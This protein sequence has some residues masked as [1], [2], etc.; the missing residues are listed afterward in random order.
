VVDPENSDSDR[1][2]GEAGE[3]LIRGPQVFKGYWRNDE[4]TR[5]V[6]TAD[7]WFKTGDI[8]R[9][10]EDFYVT[11]VDRIKEIIVTGGFNVTPT[12]VE[13]AL[14]DHDSVADA[15]VVG[16]PMAGG[17]EEVVAA[18]VLREGHQ[19]SADVLKV[20]CRGSLAA[21]KVP[22]RIVVVDELPRS[23]IGKVL[24][25]QVRDQLIAGDS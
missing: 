20:A 11:I 21:Y 1:E 17:G 13:E 3:L 5:A 14:L 6:L 9:I 18:V 22:R 4:D 25:R 15:A 16:M 12:E 7:G 10:D 23:L 24:R 19:F 2:P 8:V